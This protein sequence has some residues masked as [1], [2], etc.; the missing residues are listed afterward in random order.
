MPNGAS[1]IGDLVEVFTDDDLEHVY[2]I[3]LVKRHAIDFSLAEDLPP[4]ASE[5]ILQTSEG[6]R[7]TIPKLQ[8]VAEPPPGAA[9]EGGRRPS[10]GEAAR[11][12]HALIR[13]VDR[14]GSVR[15]RGGTRGVSRGPAAAAARRLVRSS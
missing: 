13:G 7:G 10:E 1:L 2:Q 3:T 5:L 14:P 15:G 11:L 12:L 9:G 8:V 4:G 6:P